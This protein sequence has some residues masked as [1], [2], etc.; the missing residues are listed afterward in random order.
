MLNTH[1]GEE[2]VLQTILDFAILLESNSE[3]VPA[4]P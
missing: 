2:L 3:V 4:L 1:I